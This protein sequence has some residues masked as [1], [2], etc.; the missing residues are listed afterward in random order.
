MPNDASL[1][2][3]SLTLLLTIIPCVYYYQFELFSLLLFWPEEFV[4]LNVIKGVERICLSLSEANLCVVW[5]G[6]VVMAGTVV[7]VTMF[8]SCGLRYL[9]FRETKLYS[10]FTILEYIF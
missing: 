10:L 2:L 1:S 8:V 3:C 9:F 6:N 7:G 5:D 4:F